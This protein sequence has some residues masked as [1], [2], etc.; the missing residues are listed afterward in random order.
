LQQR[1]HVLG[2]TVDLVL[3][4]FPFEAQFYERQGVP[5]RFVGHP[6]AGRVPPAL[7]R[8]QAR[9]LLG[10][11]QGGSVV[12]L[13]PG[14]RPGEVRYL[15]GPF[16][17]AARWCLAR[18]SDIHFVTPTASA[19]VA[20]LFREALERM[21]PGLPLTLVD[22]RSIEAMMAADVVLAASGTATLEAMLIPR[23]MVV[24]YRL[25][26]LTYQVLRRL[27]TVPHI[28][29]PNLLAGR[30]VVPEF[31]QSAAT[32]ENLGRAVLEYLD[33]PQ[34]FHQQAEVFGQVRRL[35]RKDSDQEAADAVL[36]LAVRRCA[37]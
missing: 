17:G 16:L 24:A 12:A 26:W 32:P 36:A 8:A 19:S 13:L 27:V 18:R 34:V 6:T 33:Q 20:A 7:S 31:L 29:L 30:A 1:L 2:G 35:L 23:P 11:P 22:G 25:S 37:A 28:A 21:A 3:T 4:L 10:L 15:A 14:S 5:V 9:S